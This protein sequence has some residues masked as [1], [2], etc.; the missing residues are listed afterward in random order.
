MFTNPPSPALPLQLYRAKPTPRPVDPH[1]RCQK[2]GDCCSKPDEVLMTRQE[3]QVLLPAIPQGIKTAWREVNDQFVALK[4][5]PC[6]FFIF[7]DC[8]VYEVRP[9][10]CRRFACL[11]PDPKLEPWEDGDGPTKCK[12][13][14]DRIATSRIAL[15]MMKLFQRKAQR[16]AL[17]YGWS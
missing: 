2:S 6:P 17:K 5:Q 10:N 8:L 16:W 9:Y 14:D 7:G 12:N 4:A 3:R 1:W 13:T 11:R 15:R